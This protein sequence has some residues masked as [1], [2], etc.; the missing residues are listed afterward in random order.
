[1]ITLKETYHDDLKKL[2]WINKNA[3]SKKSANVETPHFYKELKITNFPFLFEINTL[4]KPSPHYYA[5]IAPFFSIFPFL[6][7]AQKNTTFCGMTAL[8]HNDFL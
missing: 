4:K 6:R 8:I 1:M 5:L 2:T 7:V 3:F